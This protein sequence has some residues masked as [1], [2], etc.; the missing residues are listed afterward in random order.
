MKIWISSLRDVHEAH[1]KARPSRIV[2]LLSPGSEFPS[3]D[4]YADDR[5]HRIEVHDLL[6]DA[7][8]RAAPCETHLSLIIAHLEAWAPDDPLLVH[9]WAGMSRST[10][11]AFIAACLHNPHADEE[12]IGLALAAASPTAYPNTRIVALADAM[13]ERSGRMTRAAETLRKDERRLAEIMRVGEAEP[14]F[15]PSRY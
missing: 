13:L 3:F 15:I 14:F 1:Q 4:G 8:E 9:C 11:T 12:E 10:A 5:H 6:D 7:G 2:S